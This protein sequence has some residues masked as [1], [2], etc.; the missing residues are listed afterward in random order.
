MNARSGEDEKE[1][2]ADCCGGCVRAGDARRP[3]LVSD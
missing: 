2:G 1:G 3:P